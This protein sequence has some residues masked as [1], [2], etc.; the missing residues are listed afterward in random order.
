MS[1]K[2]YPLGPL[3]DFVQQVAPTGAKSATRGLKR[4]SRNLRDLAVQVE[5]KI[6]AAMHDIASGRI[7]FME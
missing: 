1:G 7:A 2:G 3:D 5:L 6:V 4:G